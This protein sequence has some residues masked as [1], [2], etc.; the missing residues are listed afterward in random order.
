MERVL[1]IPATELVGQSMLDVVHSD[2]RAT[3]AAALQTAQHEPVSGVEV[4]C[5]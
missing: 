2:D 1:G 3:H 4:R 5:R